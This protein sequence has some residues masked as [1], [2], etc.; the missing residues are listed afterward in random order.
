MTLH[1]QQPGHL[2]PGRVIERHPGVAAEPGLDARG[3]AVEDDLDVAVARVPRLLQP[4][5]GPGFEQRIDLVTEPVQRGPQRGPPAVL[6]AVVD[7][8]AAVLTP[9][10]DAV[11]AAP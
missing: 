9:P 6:L 2:E 11:L 1:L 10:L 3:R 4:G 8:A 5:A 7:P